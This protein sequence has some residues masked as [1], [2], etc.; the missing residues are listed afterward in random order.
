LL[1]S[2]S[3]VARATVAG[4]EFVVAFAYIANYS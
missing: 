1:L 2:S 3:K 4:T